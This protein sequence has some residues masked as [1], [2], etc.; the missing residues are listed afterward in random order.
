MLESSIL[1]VERNNLPL[2]EVLPVP[3]CNR[4]CPGC[5]SVEAVSPPLKIRSAPFTT[6]LIPGLRLI[7]PLPPS[8]CVPVV[9]LMRP[10]EPAWFPVDTVISPL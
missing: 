1:I 4:S 9:M 7:D 2:S 6:W 10:L 3:A 5:K 8:A